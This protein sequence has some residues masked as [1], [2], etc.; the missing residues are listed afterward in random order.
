MAK[1]DPCRHTMVA[2]DVCEVHTVS[3]V[4]M[5]GHQYF[6]TRLQDK[7]RIL[8]NSPYLL[9]PPDGSP[10][11]QPPAFLGPLNP[12]EACCLPAYPS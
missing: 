4:H 1:K 2:N 8:K 10:V 12:E 7:Q 6:V 3:D 9:P 11:L 5:H